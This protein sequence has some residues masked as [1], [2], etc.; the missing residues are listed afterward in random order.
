MSTAHM[1]HFNDPVRWVPVDRSMTWLAAGWKDM[2]RAHNISLGF[3]VLFAA[4]GLILL[5]GLGRVG[6]DALILPLATGF[7][8][9]GPLAAAFLY[10]TSRRLERNLPLDLSGMWANIRAHGR[11]IANL[12]L[13]LMFLFLVWQMTAFVLFALF[14]GNAPPP[15]DQL[16]SILTRPNGVPILLI[17]SVAG[18]ALGAIAFGIS[19]FAMPMLL[20]SDVST[21]EA[22]AISLRAAMLNWRN[23]IGWAATIGVISGFGML[24]AFVGLA[25][26]LPWIAHASWHAY[27]DVVGEPDDLITRP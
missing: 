14:V 27:R 11:Q 17:G 2:V 9:I 5:I 6:L 13:V 26:A 21:A 22:V 20:E 7:L 18:V 15:L 10:E 19:V 4:I 3:G 12:G 1:A 8:L 23:M 25:V 16:L 24:L